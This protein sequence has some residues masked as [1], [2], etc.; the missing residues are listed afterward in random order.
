[1]IFLQVM[2]DKNNKKLSINNIANQN[3]YDFKQLEYLKCQCVILIK[4]LLLSVGVE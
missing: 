1:M 2:N 3:P 4:G